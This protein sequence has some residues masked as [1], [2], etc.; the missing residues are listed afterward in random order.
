LTLPDLIVQLTIRCCP[1][2]LFFVHVETSFLSSRSGADKG[3]RLNP[4]ENENVKSRN[5]LNAF[6][7]SNPFYRGTI[8]KIILVGTGICGLAFSWKTFPIFPFSRVSGCILILLA[9]GFHQ[10]AHKKH[11]QAHEKAQQIEAIVTTGVFSKIRH[12]LYLSLIFTNL[13]I[14]LAFGIMMTSVLALLTIIHWV[15][16]EVK[17]EE[18]LMNRFP[19]EYARYKQRVRWRMIPWIF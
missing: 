18:A 15:L 2:R 12:P 6:F 13:G 4:T 5:V 16:T 3:K 7:L 8:E 19:A 11:K 1:A 14:A 17:E 9:Y 10:W